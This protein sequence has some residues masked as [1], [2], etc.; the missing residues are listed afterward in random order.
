MREGKGGEKRNRGKTEPAVLI[1]DSPQKLPNDRK[2]KKKGGE[3]GNA[4]TIFTCTGK[5]GSWKHIPTYKTLH[6][7]KV[8][9]R[10]K[11]FLGGGKNKKHRLTE[12]NRGREKE[13]GPPQRLLFGPGLA[14][15]KKK[16]R[17][18]REGGGGGEGHGEGVLRR[19]HEKKR[20]K[21]RV[22]QRFLSF[23]ST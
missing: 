17:K 22:G 4:V 9:E 16:K 21:E 23:S 11:G 2:K 8:V 20:K 10:E 1:F 7:F 14:R 12:G 18:K 15:P 6:E 5:G 3:R 13:K 19:T